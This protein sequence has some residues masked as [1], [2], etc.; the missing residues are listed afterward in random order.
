MDEQVNDLILP[1]RLY[2]SP[3]QS[4]ITDQENS[5][6][7]KCS[8]TRNKYIVDAYNGPDYILHTARHTETMSSWSLKSLI[9]NV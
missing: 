3:N 4:K 5:Y 1:Y 8:L 6:P 9:G 7:V 2:P